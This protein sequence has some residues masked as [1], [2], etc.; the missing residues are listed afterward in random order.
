VKGEI[1]MRQESG[2]K[3]WC[4]GFTL[5]ELLVV[6]AILVILAGLLFPV[7]AR[8]REQARQ[9]ACSSQ[10]QQIG[11]AHLIYLQDWDERF[12][13]WVQDDAWQPGGSARRYWT[14]QLQPYLRS[15]QILLDAG[16]RWSGAPEDGA[17]LA[18]YALLTWG[19]GGDG[20]PDNP[21]FHWPGPLLTLAGVR[22]PAETL[23][24]T[25]GWT[26]TEI[27]WGLERR[28][29]GAT[30][31]LFL[32]GHACRLPIGELRRVDQD[33]SG[34]YWRHYAAADR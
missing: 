32:D 24:L 22:R 29:N 4:R 21:Y 27:T 2:R 8:C 20:T 7:L 13:G 31:A 34:Y 23:C 26:T 19:P 5:M 25:D 16:A 12:P 10:I 14:Q 30:N 1:E 3:R 28:H 18:D 9:V 15:P 17:K 33:G 11:R 6:M